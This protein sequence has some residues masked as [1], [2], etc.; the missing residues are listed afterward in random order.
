MKSA[1]LTSIAA[2]LIYLNLTGC[3][4]E[5]PE[6]R[7][8][9]SKAASQD[10]TSSLSNDRSSS[11]LNNGNQ[12]SSISSTTSDTASSDAS[13]PLSY[14]QS[15]TP[16]DNSQNIA[17]NSKVIVVFTEP[18][19][20][21]S[22]QGDLITL[23]KGNEQ[24]AGSINTTDN[25]TFTFQTNKSLSAQS[26]HTVKIAESMLSSGQ[27][28]GRVETQFMSVAGSGQTSQEV[29]DQC[30]GELDI[31]MLAQVNAA[32]SQARVCG[33]TNQPAVPPLSWSCK[34][35][36]AALKH[37]Q[38]M[39]Q[40]NFFSHTGSNGS[41]LR[42]RIDGAD[43]A[44]RRIGENIAAGQRDVS[45]V[46]RGWLDSPGHCSNIMSGDFTEFGMGQ[47]TAPQTQYRIFWTQNFAK[48][49]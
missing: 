5:D 9:E 45:S 22:Y 27:T 33:S 3:S 6:V 10:T 1:V 42:S 34:L 32:R 26:L 18:V 20:E 31:E 21:N 25:Q 17:L 19:L 43:Y 14:I 2:S 15:I 24:V 29:I 4:I 37:S 47:V 16:S 44:W 28:A 8:V 11:S 46:M 30:M 39:G 7:P 49:L 13:A 38:D 12:A 48:P 35:Q 40:N 23:L 36:Q 41:T